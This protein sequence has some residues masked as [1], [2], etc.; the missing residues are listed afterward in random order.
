VNDWIGLL[1]L[2]GDWPHNSFMEQLKAPGSA[3]RPRDET[4][5]QRALAAAREVFAQRGWFGTSYDEVA[6]RAGVGKSSLYLRWPTKAELVIA[7]VTPDSTLGAINTGSARGDLVQLAEAL[8]A[9]QWSGEGVATLRFAAESP[10]VAE[11][12]EAAAK[13]AH[14][15][16][17][18]IVRKIVRRGVTKGDL[19]PGVNAALINDLIAGA[20][21]SHAIV[22]SPPRTAAARAKSTAYVELVV[23]AVLAGAAAI[24]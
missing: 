22:T 23:D 7:A 6:K 4:V 21:M 1:A 24:A 16:T 18:Q 2:C 14:S 3:G 15:D 11:L 12:R 13:V 5:G 19:S 17:L 8:L 20:V 9:A 10:H